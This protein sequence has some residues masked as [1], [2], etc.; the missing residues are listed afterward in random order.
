MAKEVNLVE[1]ELGPTSIRSL[2]QRPSTRHVTLTALAAFVFTSPAYAYLDPGTG[3]IILQGL[4]AGI[5]TAMA[6]AGM[7]WQRI[8]S[9]FSSMFC[10][11]KS[12]HP[13]SEEN[14][15]NQGP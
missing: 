7:F 3:S 1:S 15:Q 12:T 10:S 9:I 6:I 5:A 8:K 13:H 4:L 14:H 11:K 2:Q